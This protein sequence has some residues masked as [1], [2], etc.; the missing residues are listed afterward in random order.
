M[1]TITKTQIAKHMLDRLL[2]SISERL[3]RDEDLVGRLDVQIHPLI[4]IV[5][6]ASMRRD[7]LFEAARG[8]LARGADERL[9]SLEG[10]EIT[11]S[12]REGSIF[13]QIGQGKGK[14][15]RIPFENLGMLSSESKER[16]Q[17][18]DEAL[19]AIGPA[20]PDFSGLHHSAAERE[21]TA[22]EVGDLLDA[23]WHGVAGLQARIRNLLRAGKATVWNLVPESL[24][25]YERFCGPDPGDL[26]PE[27][28]L[29]FILPEYRKDLLRR[30][31]GRGL[32]ICLFGALRDDLNPGAWV[33]GVGD[34]EV[35]EALEACQPQLD[36]FSVLGALDI[37]LYRQHDARFRAFAEE[38]IAK[39]AADEFPDSDGRDLYQLLPLLGAIRVEPHS[40]A[41]E[42]CLTGAI[43]E[44]DVCLDAG[45]YGGTPSGWF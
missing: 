1:H 30:D 43:L 16:L 10:E 11:V 9:L 31:L 24:E 38:A 23:L 4:A 12:K 35:W 39:L 14:P 20:G 26:A 42:R 13:V 6:K 3:K 7:E 27:E 37:A 15:L 5:G 33:E 17:V 22:E 19:R 29:G 21:L 41:G 28:Y 44:E 45:L 18:L 40:A 25:Y 36:P 32:E 8:V 2:R 34:G